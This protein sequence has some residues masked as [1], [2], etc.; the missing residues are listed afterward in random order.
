MTA[1][2][3]EAW[4]TSRRARVATGRAGKPDPYGSAAPGAFASSA[5]ASAPSAT[6]AST[7]STASA[8]AP[9]P[10]PVPAAAAPVAAARGE[11]PGPVAGVLLQV[12]AF[13]SRD[14]AERALAMLSRAGVTGARLHDGTAAGKPVWRL[15]VGPVS[16]ALVAELSARVAGLGFGAPHPVRE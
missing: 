2:G 10:E 1:D 6:S 3:F 15:R 13:G 9:P 5:Q 4:M 16:P 11:E 7:A 12:A 8:P 14:N